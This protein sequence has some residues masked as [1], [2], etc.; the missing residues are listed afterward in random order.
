MSLV[1]FAL[2]R[3][4][5]GN[6]VD[7]LFDSAGYVSEADKAL[8]EKDLGIDKPLWAQYVDW[9]RAV[10]TGDLGKS[11]RYDQ[12][13]WQLIK[14][15]IPVTVELAFLSM[16]I[17]VLLGVPTGVISAVRQDTG[18]DYVLRVFSIAGLSMPSFW[19]GMV[20]ILSLVGWLGWIPPMI[21]VSPLQNFKLHL[22]QFLLPALAVGYRS[23][24][25]IM[26]ITRS[27]M[28]EV[29]REDYV[30]TAWAKGQ[31]GRAV[32]WRHAFKNAVLPVV[33]V[34]GIEFA[35]LIGGLVVTETVFN[36]PGVA[37][38]LVEAILWRDYPIVQ[39]LVMFIAI[40]VVLS[41]LTVDMLYG[42]LDPR[43]RYGA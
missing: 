13:A 3:L 29:L 11:Y 37:R 42:V 23:S 15:M 38:F 32:V 43:V 2:L 39:N 27:A 25:L 33:T 30:R 8:I 4:A 9:L 41:N 18:L 31:S 24:A 26:R 12:P 20:I 7:I 14:P 10:V 40:I 1:I 34:I 35:F 5:P 17:A 19:L 28:L 16:V 21:Y 6:I 36:L 22:V